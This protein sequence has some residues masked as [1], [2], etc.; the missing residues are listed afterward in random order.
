MTCRPDDTVETTRAQGRR[1]VDQP[2]SEEPIACA[3]PVPSRSRSSPSSSRRA[4]PRPDPDPHRPARRQRTRR[5]PRRHRPRAP[6]SPSPSPMP[7]DTDPV[8]DPLA[9]GHSITCDQEAT[10][11]QVHLVLDGFRDPAGWPVR[12]DG[13]CPGLRTEADGLAYV[14]C[15]PSDGATIH[16][17][18]L[19]G[20]PENGWPASLEGRCLECR[21]ER[22]LDRLRRRTIAHRGGPG[23]LHLRG[24]LDG[25]RGQHPR[26]LPRRQSASPDGRSR[27]PEIHQRPMGGAA[28]A[29]VGSLFTPM[30][31]SPG[32]TRVSSPPSSSRPV[33]PS[34]RRG[35][36]TAGS[37][38][39]G[40]AGRK[41]RRPAPCSMSTTASPT[42]AR[43]DA[44][45][46][47]M[48][49]GKSGRDGRT[50][51]TNRRHR[52]SPRTDASP[53]SRPSMTRTIVSSCSASTERWSPA[54]RSNLPADIETRCLFGDTPCAGKTSPAFAND[55]TMYL[56]L[57][58]SRRRR[59]ST[60][61][62]WVTWAVRSSRSMRTAPSSMAGRSTSPERTHLLD[63]SVEPGRPPRRA[64]LRLR[65]RVLWRGGDPAHDLHLRARWRR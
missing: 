41:A 64:W 46:A 63:L 52:T 7:P 49:A 5:A 3:R 30:G 28:T 23:R 33:G 56:S 57:A 36:S 60:G 21:L 26:V 6:P 38:P 55:G 24:D 29:A 14:A 13:P 45:G 50:S 31:S 11:C 15:S 44:C 42:S 61:R 62:P 19:D 32:A 22:S 47:T 20:Q 65:R 58:S 10:T 34:S 35:H 54:R 12:V 9:V 59:P 53:S 37:M 39:A 51:W 25:S 40:R 8:P 16:V 27:S 18:G 48:T 43:P 4:A 1:T 2:G 17:I